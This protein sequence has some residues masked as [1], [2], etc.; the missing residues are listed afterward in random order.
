MFGLERQERFIGLQAGGL[1]IG[2]TKTRLAFHQTGKARRQRVLSAKSKDAELC[3]CLQLVVQSPVT[4]VFFRQMQEDI[5]GIAAC[6]T[7]LHGPFQ[8]LR[9]TPGQPQAGNGVVFIGKTVTGEANLLMLERITQFRAIK[10]ELSVEPE[11]GA[12]RNRLQ[13]VGI[14]EI[15]GVVAD[16]GFIGD[17]VFI[18]VF[19][20]LRT[21]G[22]GKPKN[23]RDVS[24]Q[25]HLHLRSLIKQYLIFGWL[26][27][28]Q[29]RYIVEAGSHGVFHGNSRRIYRRQSR[30]T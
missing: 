21:A 23:K 24:S 2:R 8:P 14:A 11:A 3:R 7:Q 12:Q 15:I 9:Q 28:F 26:I 18:G 16:A 4:D 13:P 6:A 29:G 1:E 10:H 25:P 30:K 19:P 17:I 27:K 20:R 5:A 22:A